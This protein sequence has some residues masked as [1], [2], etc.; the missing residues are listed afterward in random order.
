[1]SVTLSTLLK[2]PCLKDATV[3]AGHSSLSR[4]VTSVS[5]LEYAQPTAL[6][7]EFF[8]K[9]RFIGS[10]V[11]LTC[12]Y[13]IRFDVEAQC[14]I[15]KG[16]A[17]YGEV[18]VILYYLGIIV[19]ELDQRV[20]DVA[21]AN[22]IALIV[23]PA[24]NISYRYSEVITSVMEAIIK[25]RTEQTLFS[26]DLL[27]QVTK[28]PEH[29]KT[30][31][32]LLCMLRD[33]LHTSFILTDQNNTLL[34]AVAYPLAAETLLVQALDTHR[35]PQSW[36]KYKR[37]ITAAKGPAM[38]LCVITTDGSNL[39][40]EL[41]RQIE[42]VV[43]LF[44]NI[45]N[46]QHNQ[47]ISEEMIRTILRDEPIKMRRLGELF[48]IDV[49]ALQE[50]WVLIPGKQGSS[51]DLCK[52]QLNRVL[53]E[54]YKT[55]LCDAYERQI[56]AFTDG[57]CLGEREAIAQELAPLGGTLFSIQHTLT[58]TEVRL[59]YLTIQETKDACRLIFEAAR[60]YTAQDLAFAKEC[61]QTIEQG[62]IAIETK[63]HCLRPTGQDSESLK[64]LATLL[65][66]CQ[67][68]IAK[69]AKKLNLHT[70]SVKYRVQKLN[71]LFG[72]EVTSFP[73]SSFLAS[74]LGIW[75]I[76]GS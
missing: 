72:S 17:N 66:D 73:L 39:S 47:F 57:F 12:W 4:P 33:R 13:N 26:G 10:E 29:L 70:N 74:A 43:Q 16:L 28:L 6:L 48:H 24:G 9:N 63:M 37:R 61:L 54:N 31:D 22:N 51:E 64:T 60:Y 25:D 67:G 11:A 30:M 38:F 71:T 49:A 1:M 7:D 41:L 56:V 3:V 75:R 34:N 32:T 21:D 40:E 8:E 14:N 42:E 15:L 58:T 69:T 45:W 62:Q 53:K 27:N 20:L 19:P 65:L 68:S 55:C 35:F 52:K 76:L 18:G 44:V 36:K 2:L 23:M 46:P 59:S 50:M 5:V